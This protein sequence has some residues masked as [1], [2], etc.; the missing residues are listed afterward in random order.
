MTPYDFLGEKEF[1][2]TI[3]N[4]LLNILSLLLKK[5]APF[6][7]VTNI[8]RVSFNPLLPEDIAKRFQAATLFDLYGYTLSSAKIENDTLQFEAGFGEDNFA[9]LVSVP[10]GAVLQ[11]F[12]DNTPLFI[13][14]SKEPITAKKIES[15]KDNLERSLK[16]LLK[17]PKNQKLLKK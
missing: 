8:S 1:V 9:S 3:H 12:I 13:N 11:I 7:V 14:M 17:N 16:V 6:S 15:K 2:E 10:I 4:A 5:R